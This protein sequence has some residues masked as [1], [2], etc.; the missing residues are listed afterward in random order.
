MQGGDKETLF[1]ER[2]RSVPSFFMKEGSKGWFA[3]LLII[4][5]RGSPWGRNKCNEK[6]II[7][8]LCLY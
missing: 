4:P 8:K 6:L 7:L 5:L 1:Y 2:M 3:E